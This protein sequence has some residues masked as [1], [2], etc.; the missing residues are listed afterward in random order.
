MPPALK[1]ISFEVIADRS[2]R[3]VVDVA[4]VPLARAAQEELLRYLDFGPG[5][6]G[7]DGCTFSPNVIHAAS[8]ILRL[9]L[10]VLA[11][12]EL[13]PDEITTGPASDGTVDVEIV[14][15]Q[16]RLIFVLDPDRPQSMTVYAEDRGKKLTE[17]EE[18]LGQRVVSWLS[19]LAALGELPA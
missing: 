19:W 16:R 13:C 3:H 10:L 14:R 1:D 6:D 15:G 2:G 5:W 11:P 17:R 8:E 4:S 18:S 12:S 9:T 7:Y